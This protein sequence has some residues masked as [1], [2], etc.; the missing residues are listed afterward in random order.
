MIDICKRVSIGGRGVYHGKNEYLFMQSHGPTAR[1]TPVFWRETRFA[2]RQ[3]QLNHILHDH[4][5]EKNITRQGAEARTDAALQAQ[6]DL[7]RSSGRDQS[8][9]KGRQRPDDQLFIRNVH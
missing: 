8:P 9:T 5:A 2:L 1:C 3:Q 4:D 6:A 7:H